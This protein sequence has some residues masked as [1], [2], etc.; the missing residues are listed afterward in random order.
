MKWY[1]EHGFPSNPF[2]SDA[3]DSDYELFG[4]DEEA[5]ELFYRISS[6]S[7][8]VI[9]GKPGSGKTALLKYA[10]DNFK[11]EGKVV[12]VDANKL[13]KNFNV[14]NLIKEKPKGMIMLLDN[15]HNLSEKNNLRIKYFFDEDYI[16]SVVFTTVDYGTVN[17]S[18]PIKS[19]IGKN[20]IKLRKINQKS[21][22]AIAKERFNGRDI[23]NDT[24]IKTAY[25]GSETAKEFLKAC[26]IRIRGSE[27]GKG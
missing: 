9:E 19:R 23:L 17:F 16:A 14:T 26:E 2:E 11:G 22:L 7:M 25:R 6:G 27:R 3:M 20:I 12:Y 8:V 18:D 24:E 10:I 13:D 21:S 4:R 5:K 15:V 1:E